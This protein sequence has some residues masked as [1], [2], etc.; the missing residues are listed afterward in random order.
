V[1]I[2]TGVLVLHMVLLAGSWVV[3]LPVPHPRKCEEG[4]VQPLWFAR[5]RGV[6][7]RTCAVHTHLVGVHPCVDVGG[8]GGSTV[9]LQVHARLLSLL[10]CML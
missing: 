6:P 1:F 2:H 9:A 8:W 10:C 5:V 4:V 7:P 3:V